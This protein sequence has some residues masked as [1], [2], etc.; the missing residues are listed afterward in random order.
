MDNFIGEV[1]LFAGRYA[2]EGWAFCDGSALQISQNQALFALIGVTYGGDG[3]TNFKLPDLR[4]RLPLGQGQGTGLTNRVVGQSFG[5]ETVTLQA[6]ELPTHTHTLNASTTLAATVTP[7]TTVA[8]GQVPGGLYVDTTKGAVTQVK[9]SAASV[10]TAGGGQ[11]HANIMPSFT[12]TY[13][14]ATTGMFP[15]FNN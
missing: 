4:G 8:L 9:P 3:V 11:P 12:L 14:I 1:R 13:I 6:N 15:D 2:P 10:G 5:S 7:G